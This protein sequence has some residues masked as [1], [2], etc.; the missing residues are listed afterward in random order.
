M[1]HAGLCSQRPCRGHD[2]KPQQDSWKHIAA[3]LTACCMSVCGV[4]PP[5]PDRH[6]LQRVGIA[7]YLP[8]YT[9]WQD[10]RDAF[11]ECALNPV[12]QIP[13]LQGR[14]MLAAAAGSLNQHL[15]EFCAHAACQAPYP[16]VMQWQPAVSRLPRDCPQCRDHTIPECSRGG[17]VAPDTRMLTQ[18][19]TCRPRDRCTFLQGPPQHHRICST[20][21]RAGIWPWRAPGPGRRT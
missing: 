18:A 14:T 15:L 6:V 9:T 20:L 5:R 2:D 7:K 1:Q 13:P 17:A 4:D 8:H 16:A 21:L 19:A 3:S 10:D 12:P 11:F